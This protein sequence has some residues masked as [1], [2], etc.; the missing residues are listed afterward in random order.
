[1]RRDVDLLVSKLG[2]IEG[3]DSVGKHLMDIVNAKKIE[4]PALPYQPVLAEETLKEE[5][6]PAEDDE[7]AE[8]GSSGKTSEEGK[9]EEDEQST[10]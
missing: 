6:K 5:K 9:K 2:K 10:A 1:M 4:A 3:F 7:K 8:A